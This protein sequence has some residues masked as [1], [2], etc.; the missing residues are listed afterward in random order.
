[1]DIE[2]G[3]SLV[4]GNIGSKHTQPFKQTRYISLHAVRG[5]GGSVYSC[6]LRVQS[7]FV[8]GQ[9]AATK[10]AAQPTA[11]MLVTSNCSPLLFGF[12]VSG[13]I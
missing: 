9:W 8:Y 6:R 3:I 2:K 7:P 4:I 1:M 13:G 11:V 10:C 12:P 5:L